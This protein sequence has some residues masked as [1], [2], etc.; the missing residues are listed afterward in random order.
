MK[1]RMILIDDE[2]VILRG[3]KQLVD[4]EQLNIEIVG[5]ATDGIEG[6]NIIQQL[7]PDIVIS[8]IAMPNLNGIE[9]L[10]TVHN[11]KIG[12]KVIFLSG[13]QEFSY[14]KEAV[15]YGAEDYL[16]K[17]IGAKELEQVV[18]QVIM[19]IKE[20]ESVHVLKKKDCEA[21]I[22]FQNMLQEQDRL[23]P[24][25]WMKELLKVKE[26][27]E[28]AVC[29]ALRIGVRSTVAKEEN[30]N[31]IRFEIFE[32]IQEYL[33][34]TENGGII[35]KEYNS[36]YILLFTENDRKKYRLY[37][38]KL[39]EEI[40]KK[41]PA[42]VLIG[43]GEWAKCD[44]KLYYMYS[45][46]KFAAELY[47]FNEESYNDISS[48]EKEYSHS[49]DEY[50]TEKEKIAQ[51][52]VKQSDSDL[53]VEQILKCVKLLGTIHFGNKEVVINECILLAGSIYQILKECGF[54]DENEGN[55]QERF[56]S[57]IRQKTSFRQL[58]QVFEN[59]YDKVF[60]KIQLLG[61]TKESL[62][63]VRIK[64]YIE[65]HY[66]EN[67]TLE[68][69][70]DY[71]GMN[72]SYMSTYFKKETGENFKTYLTNQRMQ[73]ALRLLNSTTMKSYEIADAVGYKDVKQFRE[74]FKETYGMSPQQYKKRGEI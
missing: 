51:I 17:P 23:M 63:I 48:I 70:A 5:E 4:W 12:T 69:I 43:V 36:C 29:A 2:A 46:A 26:E 21:E 74:K 45:T 20:E 31:L 14:A 25:L 62:E 32:Y 53:I 64:K 66:R 28:G 55:E 37:L 18:E 71:I 58:L 9:L 27:Y 8:D 22:V 30:K 68:D 13:Y 50:E 56:L 57:Q 39:S 49:V 34:R 42:V 1:Y 10:K 73:E 19:K 6:L 47:F 38:Q 52:L 15:K 72:P 33:Q 7:S 67:L 54:T 3:L 11:E 24:L 35:K 41:Y 65:D 59:Y 16:L 40:G 60:L 44:T 61:K